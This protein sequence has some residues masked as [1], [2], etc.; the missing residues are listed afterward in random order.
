VKRRL[1]DL[2]A[3]VSLALCA[4]AVLLWTWS[5]DQADAFGSC[6]EHSPLLAQVHGTIV[7]GMGSFNDNEPGHHRVLDAGA[8]DDIEQLAYLYIYGE[9]YAWSAGRGGF[10]IATSTPLGD[11]NRRNWCVIFPHWALVG[12]TA[13]A[14]AVVGIRSIRRRRRAALGRCAGCGYD[15]RATPERCPECGEI[16]DH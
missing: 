6:V 15:M 14:P 8:I 2:V 7:L 10:Y 12:V 13:I 16:P 9:E 3:G 4:C 5:Y 1:F 11:A